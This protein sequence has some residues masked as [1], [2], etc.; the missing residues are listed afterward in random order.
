VG[1]GVALSWELSP[2]VPGR[3]CSRASQEFDEHESRLLSDNS[4]AD[5]HVGAGGEPVPERDRVGAPGATGQVHAARATGGN[6]RTSRGFREPRQGHRA[7]HGDGRRRAPPDY[8]TGRV[9]PRNPVGAQRLPLLP[10][11]SGVGSQT[12]CSGRGP[13]RM[14]PLPHT[15]RTGRREPNGVTC[16]SRKRHQLAE[17]ARRTSPGTARVGRSYR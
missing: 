9:E 2:V 16:H 14:R 8:S 17:R 12:A 3:C 1:P 15:A 11:P 6:L 4:C 7:I 13:R 5:R 10:L